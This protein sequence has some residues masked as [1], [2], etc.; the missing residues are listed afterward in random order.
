MPIN[1]IIKPFGCTIFLENR[2]IMFIFFQKNVNTLIII[3]TT[4]ITLW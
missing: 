3:S 4:Y 1:N 2:I